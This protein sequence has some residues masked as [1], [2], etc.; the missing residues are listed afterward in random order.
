MFCQIFIE[1]FES[2]AYST[3]PLENKSTA[4]VKRIEEDL[5]TFLLVSFGKIAFFV[6]RCKKL[7]ACTI[8]ILHIAEIPLLSLFK[9]AFS[10]MKTLKYVVNKYLIIFYFNDQR[11]IVNYS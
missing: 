5:R 2:I 6:L 9:F 4:L 11:Y 7:N 3:L 10:G 1:Q 8:T